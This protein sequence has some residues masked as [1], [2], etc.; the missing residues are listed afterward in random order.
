[1]QRHHHHHHHHHQQQ[2]P[3]SADSSE[4]E[5]EE[6][7]EEEST[8]SEMMKCV[9][10]KEEYDA[11]EAGTCRE[12]YEEASETEEEL[13]R[14]IEELKSKVNFLRFWT[15]LDSRSHHHYHRS[16]TPCFTD[17]LLVA[18]DLDSGKPVPNSVPVPAN[19]AV[20]VTIPPKLIL[21]S[22]QLVQVSFLLVRSHLL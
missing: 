3:P 9:S 10:C 13:K 17:V 6:D 15:P 5:E 4:E 11:D 20:L 8:S 21:T 18:V 22:Q 7:R 14:E 12:C 2:R 1:M 19:K 16:T